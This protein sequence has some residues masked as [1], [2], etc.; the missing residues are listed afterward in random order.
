LMNLA[1]GLTDSQFPV[2]SFRH[3]LNELIQNPATLAMVKEE[4]AAF[5]FAYEGVAYQGMN[6]SNQ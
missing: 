6:Y 2:D 5:L 3:C 4:A 1:A